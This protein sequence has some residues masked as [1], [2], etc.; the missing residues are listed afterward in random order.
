M[1][2]G[3][4]THFMQIPFQQA[5]DFNFDCTANTCVFENKENT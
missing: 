2:I 5:Y 3:K 1:F 4:K